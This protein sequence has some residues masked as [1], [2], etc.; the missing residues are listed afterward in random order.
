MEAFKYYC[1]EGGIECVCGGGVYVDKSH[2]TRCY[3]GYAEVSG[4]VA[5]G[6]TLI[7]HTFPVVPPPENVYWAARLPVHHGQ[8]AAEGRPPAH[9]ADQTHALGPARN[10]PQEN[11]HS[12]VHVGGDRQVS[13]LL[14]TRV[15]GVFTPDAG[16]SMY[17]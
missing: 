2:I 16:Q 8:P 13:V 14:I 1:V 7:N 15:P 3:H 5:E 9:A 4:C 6:Y 17:V 10:A 12:Q 11:L